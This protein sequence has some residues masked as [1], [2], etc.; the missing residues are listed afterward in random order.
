MVRRA[1]FIAWIALG[2]GLGALGGGC[3]A[4]YHTGT[5]VAANS[6]F[7]EA[8]FAGVEKWAFYEFYKAQEFLAK[9]REEAGYSDFEAAIHFAK[10]SHRASDVALKKSAIHKGTGPAPDPIVH[11]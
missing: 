11:E 5:I 2:I 1:V 10:V 7:E 9:S 3:A 4:V 8:C 6:A